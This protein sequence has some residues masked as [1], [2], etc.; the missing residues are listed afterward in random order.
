MERFNLEKELIKL[1]KTNSADTVMSSLVRSRLDD[2][3]A[4]LPERPTQRISRP[5]RT[6]LRRTTTATAAA[7]I[8]GAAFFASG[9]VSPVMADSIKSIPLIGSIFSS[10][11]GDIGL[12]NAGD[13]GLAATVNRNVSYE[14]VKL[15]VSETVFDGSRA[16][17]LVHV[18]A[19][20]L[21][22]GKYDNGKKLVKLSNAI[23][24]VFF[25]VNGKRQGDPGSILKG[26]GYMGAG[27]AHPD[28]L[29]FEEVLDTSGGGSVPDSFNAEVTIILEGIDH[30]FKLDVPFRKTTDNIINVHPN[31]VVTKNE[32]TFSVTDLQVTPL[33]TRVNYSIALNNV[34]S[35]EQEDEYKKLR[36]VG[37]AAFDDQGRK[38]PE[39]HGDGAY[40]GNRLNY[41]RRYA[42]TLGTTK[43]LILKPFVIKD[44]FTENVKEDQYIKGLETKIELPASK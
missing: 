31:A 11:Q 18:T 2:T 29:I 8:L 23:Q 30:E 41:D 39:L 28:M 35:L 33:T 5:T 24:N 43:Y 26:G 14:D 16:A 20:N 6:R 34:Q 37:I 38:L 42:S 10:I 32:F 25:T 4:A 44:D 9:L 40:E 15:E 19:P 3:Y 22:N 12:R 21:K 1:K 13:L 36:R 27:E 7:V 17:F